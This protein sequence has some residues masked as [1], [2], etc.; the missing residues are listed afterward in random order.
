[1]VASTETAGIERQLAHY[2]DLTYDALLGQLPTREPRRYLYDLIAGQL[3]HAGK[4]L[5]PALCIATCRAFGGSTEQ[6]L[7][8][9]VSIELLHNAFLVHDDIEDG[10]LYRRNE[11]AL[12]VEEG[13][14]IALN[15]GDA[16]NVL[17][18]GSLIENIPVLGADL[19]YRVFHEAQHLI[20]QSVEGQALEL[21]WTRDNVVD[22]TEDD[23]LRVVLKKTCWYTAIHPCRIGALIG[24]AGAVDADRF[25]LFGFL[26]G[27]AFQ[28]Q[29]DVLNLIGDQGR[30]GKEIL[31]DIWEGKRTLML[32]HALRECTADEREELRRV[33]SVGRD[34]RTER[35]VDWVF[36]LFQRHG[37]IDFARA[38]LRQVVHAA[39]DEFDDAYRDAPGVADRDFIRRL[40]PYLGDRE[41]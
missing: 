1:M 31:G 14:P 36:R 17:S 15:V 8:S 41:V 23:Y 26:L 12:Y 29:D 21:G 40:I 24:T 13:V 39:Q 25:N 5:R 6:A 2:R 35:D 18:I 34:R 10:S 30:Y 7:P 33:F 11:A 3:S 4:G 28:I 16:M 19:S 37:S 22:L 20:L 32:V 38:A 27:A 9:A